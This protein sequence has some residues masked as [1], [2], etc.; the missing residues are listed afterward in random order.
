MLSFVNSKSTKM[1]GKDKQ[2]HIFQ[3]SKSYEISSKVFYYSRILLLYPVTLWK[4]Y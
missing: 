4:L 3:E 1:T 2:S